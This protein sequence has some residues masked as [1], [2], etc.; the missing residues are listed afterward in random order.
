MQLKLPTPGYSARL[1]ARHTRPVDRGEERTVRIGPWVLRTDERG[2]LI[3]ANMATGQDP[4]ILARS[5]E[6]P[7]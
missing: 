2:D 5:V 6:R 4:I 1:R 3:I 7:R